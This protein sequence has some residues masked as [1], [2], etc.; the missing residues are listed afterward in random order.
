MTIPHFVRNHYKI[1]KA[2]LNFGRDRHC[3]ICGFSFRRFLPY[4]F[5]L[6]TRDDA[7]C[8]YCGSLERHRLLWIF[9]KQ[10][11]NL[12]DGRPKRVLH[13]APEPCIESRISCSIGSG[14]LT[15]DLANPRAMVKMDVTQIEFEDESFD[16][17]ICNHVL[18]HIMDDRK[19]MREFNRILKPHGWA[20][21]LV[22][23]TAQK[24]YEDF[25]ITSPR[26]RL[27]AFGQEDHVRR[28]GPDYVDRLRE[29]GFAVNVIFPAD[30]MQRS[31][32]VRMG[33]TSSMTGEIYCC[34]K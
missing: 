4:D 27:L 33:L 34:T 6:E 25:S 10:R 16:V 9:L 30:L 20:I 32:V 19:A 23:I 1:I 24:T 21:L 13:V 15:A 5:A 28:Y 11:T 8:I 22:P 31:D 26:E 14:Y 3:P 29:S 17:I 7:V 18:E 12:F 2:L